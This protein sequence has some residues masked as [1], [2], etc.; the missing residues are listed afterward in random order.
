MSRAAVRLVIEL[1]REPGRFTDAEFRLLI[2]LPDRLNEQTGQLNP[3]ITTMAADMGRELDAAA[4]LRPRDQAGAVL[5]RQLLRQLEQHKELE[6]VD[7]AHKGGQGQGRRYP[8]Q[9]YRLTLRGAYDHPTGGA[10]DSPSGGASGSPQ[11]EPQAPTGGASGSPNLGIEP[12]KRTSAAEP[13]PSRHRS[14]S[15]AKN[16]PADNGQRQV[17]DPRW[18][19]LG[20]PTG[21]SASVKAMVAE[22]MRKAGLTEATVHELRV[23]GQDPPP[24]YEGGTGTYDP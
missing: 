17:N 24:A 8:S 5:V 19:D 15:A 20:P 16:N 7:P 18:R 4:T 6:R 10:S 3:S 9:S 23:P 2:N 11:G 13:A 1:A 21:I 12:R 14:G 22:E